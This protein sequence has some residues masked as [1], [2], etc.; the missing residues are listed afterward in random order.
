M[1]E[2]VSVLRF[3]TYSVDEMVFRRNYDIWSSEQEIELDFNLEVNSPE[4]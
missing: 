3:H 4:E 1:R 2:A